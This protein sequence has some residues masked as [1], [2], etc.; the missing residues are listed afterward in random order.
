MSN[1]M[2]QEDEDPRDPAT[3][4]FD[5]LRDELASVRQSVDALHA[6]IQQ[7]RPH[8][9]RR[10]LARIAEHPANRLDELLP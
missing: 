10:T 2:N 9:Y 1:H 6:G 5:A 4:A 8:D 7:S 3:R